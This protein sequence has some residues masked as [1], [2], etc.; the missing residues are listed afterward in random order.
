MRLE[1]VQIGQAQDYGDWVTATYKYQ[2][3]GPVFVEAMGL[4][5]DEVADHKNHGGP[6]KAVL[7][8]AAAHYSHWRQETQNSDWTGGAMGENLT[9]AGLDESTVCVGD[10]WQI[11][12]TVVVQVSQPRQPCWKQA[13]RWGIKDLVVR[14]LDTGRTGWYLRVLT[15]GAISPGDELT[16]LARPHPDWTIA[17]ANQVMHF[18]KTNPGLARALAALPELSASWQRDL[19]RRF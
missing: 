17:R 6:D 19:A 4:N 14:I 16:L 8:Y 7:A 10:T 13:K 9:I 5:G 1:S 12:P 15:E 2:I 18:D 11:G 3:E